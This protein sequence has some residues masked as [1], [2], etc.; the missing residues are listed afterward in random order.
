MFFLA[1]RGLRALPQFLAA[2]AVPS[3]TEA[4]WIPTAANA[5]AGASKLRDHVRAD[6]STLFPLVELDLDR[7]DAAPLKSAKLILVTGGDPAHLVQRLQAPRVSALLKAAIARNVPYIGIS[8]GAIAVGPSLEP[9]GTKGPALGLVPFVVL[10]H[11][12]RAD[13]VARNQA[14]EQRFGGRLTLLPLRDDQAVI[15]DNAGHRIVES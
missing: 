4:L 2:C 8:A 15:V 3:G 10:P 7:Q 1:S 9:Y 14:L 5:I 6:L 12:Q 11:A 13:R